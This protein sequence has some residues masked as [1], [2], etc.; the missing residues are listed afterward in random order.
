MRF[1]LVVAT[2]I[3]L[4]AVVAAVLHRSR[5][6]EKA[7]ARPTA[8]FTR[9]ARL[10]AKEFLAALGRERLRRA[11]RLLAPDAPC[12]RMLVP[13]GRPFKPRDVALSVS[14]AQPQHLYL[15]A[16]IRIERGRALP[17]SMGLKRRGRDRW[18]VD[19]WDHYFSPVTGMC[20]AFQT[21]S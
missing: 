13:V 8:R 6:D 11:R 7:P 1:A 10:T 18:V 19:Y 2:A 17:Y 14:F 3:A 21:S 20:A 12:S 9:S 5:A 4:V 15:D 16:V